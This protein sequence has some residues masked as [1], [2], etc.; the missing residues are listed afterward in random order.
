[1]KQLP[2]YLIPNTIVLG[3]ILLLGACDNKTDR[4][5]DSRINQGV[6]EYDVSYPYL[7]TNDIGL[8]LLP[9]KMTLTFKDNIYRVESIGGMGLFAAGFIANNQSK[10]MDYFMK[11]ISTK[12]ASRFTEKG[13]KQFHSEF[14]SY[15]LHPLDTTK[16][17]AGYKCKGTQIQFY[18]N[19]VPDYIIWYTED[20]NIKDPNWCSPFP[21]IDGVL[22]EYK[23]QQDGLIL[24]MKANSVVKD[25]IHD[26]QF[27][28][29]L[30]Y[31][32]VSNHTL[33]K[34]MEE[35]FMGFDY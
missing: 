10:K 25:S 28:V 26:S 2:K 27:K 14:P 12:L 23:L 19:I 34:K 3:L 8:S 7:D 21:N 13:L 20:I 5:N 24:S 30:E 1:M 22:M 18:N 35:A 31:K 16:M 33:I 32:V 29:P 15:Q 17:I 6:I 4:L 11:I 9:D